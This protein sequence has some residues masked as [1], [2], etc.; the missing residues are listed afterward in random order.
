[1][2]AHLPNRGAVAS[3]PARLKMS[4]AVRD[5]LER[6]LGAAYRIE[7]E[8]G[9]GGMS[10]V[11]LATETAL[12]REVVVKLL[13]PEMAAAVSMDRFKR[14]I[15]L[16]A[17]LQHPHI[18]PVLT[19]GD[20]NGLPYFTMPFIAGESLRARL[21]NHGEM[22]VAEAARVLREIASALAYAH[23]HGIVHRDIKP[24]NVLLSGGAAMVTDFGV[25]KAL[26]SSTSD[27]HASTTSLGVALGTPAYMS[28]EQA[29]AD[30]SVDH[31]ADIYS[32]GVLAYEML[33][34]HTPFFGRTPQ[35]LLAAHVTEAPELVQKRRA[36][37]PPNLAV[38]VMRC[39]EKRP[40]DRPQ[41]A[42][43]I[44]HALD[45]L[46]TPSGGM[47]PTGA[48]LPMG[49]AEGRSRRRYLTVIGIALLLVA[50][51]TFAFR[52]RANA[53]ALALGRSSELTS[54]PGL[55][56]HPDISPDG[57]LV[58]FAS[59]NARRMRIYIRPVAGGRTI[60]LS[61]DTAAVET[62][63][64][65]SPDGS[66][67][68]FLT[69]GGV[70]IAPALGGSARPVIAGSLASKVTCATWSP[71]GRKIAY[72]HADT[73]LSRTLA[74]QVTHALAR[75]AEPYGCTWSPNGKWIAFAAGNA[76]FLSLNA[77]FGNAAPSSLYLV[78]AAGGEAR[79]VT[80]AK[81][82]HEAPEWS[83]DGTTLFFVSDRDG[84]R[85]LYGVG[86]DGS[87]QPRGEAVR[88]TTG[89]NLQSASLS[90]DASRIAYTVFTARANIW[91]IEIPASGIASASTGAP[92]TTGNQV[93]ESMQV[94]R[95]GR[96][97]LY[98]SNLSGF[99]NIYRMP[100]GGGSAEQL[101]HE[102]FH[103]FSPDLSPDS[104]LLAYHSFRRGERDIEVK[105]LDGGPLEYVAQT[106]RSESFPR[107]SPDGSQLVFCDQLPPFGVF[108]STRRG[109][110]Q[111][112]PAVLRAYGSAPVW[113]PDGKSILYIKTGSLA[114]AI[115]PVE[116]GAERVVHTPAP[117]EGKQRAIFSPDGAT[118]YTKR[119][120]LDGQASFWAIPV[121]GGSAR[122]LVRFTDPAHP[123]NR[124][125]FA[126]DGKRLFYSVEER[127]SNVWVA[128]VV[129]R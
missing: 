69:N 19:A 87:G 79:A 127:Q 122:M 84:P 96:F 23:E 4:N 58:A 44:V 101:T 93:I 95:D 38:L 83:R 117:G 119:H 9:G 65:W 42:L 76:G 126:S 47:S 5:E 92:V 8:L 25:A 45:D 27:E 10:R 22:P 107:W 113:S 17:R 81:S 37:V 48:V 30:P 53:P 97:L 98:D 90:V 14:E 15:L 7:R 89:L 75:I 16:A 29:S 31:R 64:R 54:D 63:P 74:D 99:S 115:M 26:S 116:A 33:T 91:S 62:N 1:M 72:T 82:M 110:N 129:K 118:I 123:S 35:G 108:L 50:V 6:S 104:R 85:D 78:P 21:V 55:Q 32:F 41:T 51:A 71:D 59:G 103:L 105:P 43:E 94:S 114:L 68:L 106:S 52:F 80:D 2:F 66:Q 88:L 121:A 128:D 11:F 100:L 124:E 77:S 109:P 102:S 57:K 40:A 112:T 20:A 13:P 67:L 86:I 125:E 120:D 46:T 111:W 36:T 61:D 24:D 34:G 73:I 18:V 70:S 56:I 60:P 3:L 28:P 49:G 12:G 39:L